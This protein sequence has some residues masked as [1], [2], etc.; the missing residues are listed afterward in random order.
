MSKR[1]F[2]AV[3]LLCSA[4]AH[5]QGATYA[6]DPTHTAVIYETLHFG[7]STNRGRIQAKEGSVA[8]DREAR[9]GKL[10]V[11]LDLTSVSSGVPR[12]D[13]FLKG[14]DF[15]NV[16]EHPTARFAADSFRFEG[17]KLTEVS[18][19]LTLAGTTN[20]V[21]LKAM[22]FNCYTSPML[23]REVCGG[24]FEATLLRSQWGMHWGLAN[25][26]PDST[27]VLVQVEAIRQ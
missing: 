27:R 9:K 21:T 15:F 18:G 17:D 6:I 13:S 25:G 5:A 7:T 24:D 2:V 19:T 12:L 26:F 1:Y 22:H 20:P 3:A 14:K 4:T 11:T 16:A 23:R 8:F 10:D